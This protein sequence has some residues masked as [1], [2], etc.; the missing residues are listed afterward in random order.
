MIEFKQ[1]HLLIIISLSTPNPAY[2]LISLEDYELQVGLS[3]TIDVSKYYVDGFYVCPNENCDRKWVITEI[4]FRTI[5]NLNFISDT[6]LNIR[7]LDTCDMNAWELANSTV[8]I[9]HDR[10][11]TDLLS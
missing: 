7:W 5:F 4:I 6:K 11:C 3:R 1:F 9:V 10:L 8:P 2:D